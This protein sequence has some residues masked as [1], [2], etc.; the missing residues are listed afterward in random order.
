LK[1]CSVNSYQGNKYC[2]ECHEKSIANKEASL[3]MEMDKERW[4]PPTQVLCMS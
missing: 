1:C 2:G 3:D 4:A